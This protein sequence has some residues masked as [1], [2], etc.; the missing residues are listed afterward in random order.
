VW[1]FSQILPAED[2]EER[3]TN[4]FCWKFS[5]GFLEKWHGKT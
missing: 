1:N 4:R 2:I 5:G 3:K